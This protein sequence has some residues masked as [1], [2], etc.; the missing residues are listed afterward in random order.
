MS[1]SVFPVLLPWL[2]LVHQQ[3]VHGDL[4]E[5]Q[6]LQLRGGSKVLL[7][8]ALRWWLRSANDGRLPARWWLT[9]VR[10]VEGCMCVA[11]CLAMK[12]GLVEGMFAYWHNS[13]IGCEFMLVGE[14][15]TL[16]TVICAAC[17][18]H[19]NFH[20]KEIDDE[21]SSFHHRSQ[22]PPPCTI[23]IN[24][25]HTI[26]TESRSIQPPEATSTT[27]SP[28]RLPLVFSPRSHKFFFLS[29]TPC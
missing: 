23:T 6:V 20:R 26:T 8:N 29:Q 2:L 11:G 10:D 14:D 25:P 27:T 13:F 17:N 7:M 16:E 21:M 3:F 1:R 4:M 28:L 5:V 9:V 15:G 19:Q 22:P 24:S 12:E 18:C